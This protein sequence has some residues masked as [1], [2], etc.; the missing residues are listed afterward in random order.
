MRFV[1]IS[2]LLQ[3]KE[4]AGQKRN[5]SQE[6]SIYSLC[7]SAASEQILEDTN[8]K[9]RGSFLLISLENE[10]FNTTAGSALRKLGVRSDDIWSIAIQDVNCDIQEKVRP[11]FTEIYNQGIE[12]II[13]NMLP[14]ST[15][16]MPLEVAF[17]GKAAWLCFE[18]TLEMLKILLQLDMNN[19]RIITVNCNSEK[20]L[21]SVSNKMNPWKGISR[22]MVASTDLEAKQRVIS[23]ELRCNCDENAFIKLILASTRETAEERIA[24]TDN[25]V[26]Q[27]V[28]KR[29]DL[30]VSLKH[31]LDFKKCHRLG[32]EGAI[33]LLC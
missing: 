8:A 32:V 23:T 33:S 17:V 13:L 2:S 11:L 30:M 24:I 27:P 28:I 15:N 7:W 31:N 25:Q 29:H 12:M 14:M 19:S 9:V 3:T 1:I 26:L 21:Y 20:N 6:K 4:L 16:S 22:G 18:S 5:P 10:E